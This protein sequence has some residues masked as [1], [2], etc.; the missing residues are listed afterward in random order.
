MTDGIAIG[1]ITGTET[2]KNKDGD[3]NVRMLTVEITSATD[4]QTVEQVCESGEDSHPQ[5]GTRVIVLDLSPSYRVAVAADDGLE[6]SVSAGEKEFY[7][8]TA[9]LVKQAILKLLADGTIYLNGDADNAVRYSA[10]ETAFNQL[11]DDHNDLI[12]DYNAH[13]HPGVTAGAASTAVKVP[14]SSSSTA[15]ISGAKIDEITVP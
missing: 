4:V 13:V 6:P 8:Y 14:P 1:T 11:R 10:L 3:E 2:K 5:P 9:S 15:D 7:S 12:I